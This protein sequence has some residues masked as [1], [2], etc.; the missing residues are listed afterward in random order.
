MGYN[1]L[2]LRSLA[3]FEQNGALNPPVWA[4]HARF[5]P[6]RSAFTYLLRLHRF[7]LLRRGRDTRGRITYSLS[8]RGRQRLDWLRQSSRRD[9]LLR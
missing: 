8:A 2:K 5:Y 6:F 3:I 9:S 7:G 4:V 1:K